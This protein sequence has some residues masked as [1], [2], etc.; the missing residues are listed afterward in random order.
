MRALAEFVMRGRGQA[1]GVAA[2][3]VLTLLFAWV[4]AAVVALVTLRRG[5]REGL[6][7]LGWALLPA[8]GVALWGGD[9]GPATALI[10]ALVAA[11]MLRATVSWPF[12]LIASVLVGLLTAALLQTLGGGYVERLLDVVGEFLEQWRAQLPAESAAQVGEP[13]AAQVS[14][15]LGFSATS[16][17][18]LALLLARWWQALLYNPG[19][20]RTEFHQLRLP[21]VVTVALVAAGA[22]IALLGAEYQLWALMFAV[23]FTVA[24]FAAAHWVAGAKGWG[25]GIL[26]AFYV[27]WLFIDWVKLGVIL[28]ALVDSFVDL[29]RRAQRVDRPD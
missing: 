18:V 21:P 27:M 19:G 12:A 25:R 1:I 23:P 14:G 20:F 3:G 8:L 13:V 6:F 24:G 11:A 22:L 16:S 2:V 28:L 5:T 29:R 7:I 17:T 26:V 10:G 9:I 15:L 4:S